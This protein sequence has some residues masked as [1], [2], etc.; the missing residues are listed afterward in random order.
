V[1]PGDQVLFELEL[2][3]F[4]RGICKMQGVGRVDGNV[5]AEAKLMARVM[6]R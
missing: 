5:V 4:R 6:D 1:L 2:L 3:Q